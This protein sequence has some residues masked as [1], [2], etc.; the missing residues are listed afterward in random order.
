MNN[1]DINVSISLSEAE[2]HI[3]NAV[4]NG[5]IS[6]ELIDRYVINKA[7]KSFCVINVFEKHYYRTGTRL[8][9]TVIYDNSNGFTRI[10]AI[11]GGGRH[12]LFNLDWGA[13][14]NFTSSVYSELESFII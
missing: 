14:G 11:S 3:Y 2:G 13:S 8:T 5:S 9:L 12:G 4:V 10:H 7:N 1:L 6:G